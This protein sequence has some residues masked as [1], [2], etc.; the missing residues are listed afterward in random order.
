V[1]YWIGKKDWK[2]YRVH[3]EFVEAKYNKSGE[4]MVEVLYTLFSRDINEK[5]VIETKD[6]LKL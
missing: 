2:R 5:T 3:I 1:A 4:R 6:G